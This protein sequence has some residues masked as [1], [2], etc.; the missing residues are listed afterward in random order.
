LVEQVDSDDRNTEVM[1]TEP[2]TDIARTRFVTHV[3]VPPQRFHVRAETFADGPLNQVR[4][5][6]VGV[7]PTAAVSL[8]DPGGD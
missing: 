3:V 2:N 4:F 6:L 8:S 1:A 7:T 5:S